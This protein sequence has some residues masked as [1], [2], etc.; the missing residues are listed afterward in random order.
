MNKIFYKKNK[1]VTLDKIINL[2]KIKNK[3]TYKKIMINDI[4]DSHYL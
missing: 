2:L 3:L 4:K 1:N